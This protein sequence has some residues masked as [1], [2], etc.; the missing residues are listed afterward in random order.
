MLRNLL[1]DMYD[2]WHGADLGFFVLMM[3]DTGD[4]VHYC[5]YSKIVLAYGSV[6]YKKGLKITYNM[7]F[8]TNF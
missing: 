4:E 7:P 2:T 6:A 5:G 3:K 8:P 1:D